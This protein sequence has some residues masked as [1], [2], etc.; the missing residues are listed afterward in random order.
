MLSTKGFDGS[1]RLED[2]QLYFASERHEGDRGDDAEQ[3]AKHNGHPRSRS[4]QEI[5]ERTQVLL[6]LFLKL[7][8]ISQLWIISHIPPNGTQNG[9]D[10]I[11]QHIIVGEC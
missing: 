6:D 3:A 4:I 1:S 10:T 11:V 9:A 7:A 2:G 5:P 8:R